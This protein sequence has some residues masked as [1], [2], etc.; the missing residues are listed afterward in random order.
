MG[1]NFNI[2]KIR[3]RLITRGICKCN[4]YKPLF[5]IIKTKTYYFAVKRNRPY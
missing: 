1:I 3:G 4:I 5:N 2:L